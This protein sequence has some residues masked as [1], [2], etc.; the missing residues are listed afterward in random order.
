MVTIYIKLYLQ[1]TDSVVKVN[2]WKI[3]THEIYRESKKVQTKR[4]VVV[5]VEGL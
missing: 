2:E 5:Q 4:H 3:G 1:Y